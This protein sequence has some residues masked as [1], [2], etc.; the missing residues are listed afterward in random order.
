[1]KIELYLTYIH[2]YQSILHIALHVAATHKLIN[3][4]KAMNKT[5]ITH[6]YNNIK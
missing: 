2:L 6:C 3:C 1:M 5:V 4:S